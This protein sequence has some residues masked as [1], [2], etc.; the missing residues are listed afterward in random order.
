MRARRRRT[1]LLAA[2]AMLGL[3]ISG[4]G[5]KDADSAKGG[6]GAQSGPANV[7]YVVVQPTSVPLTT[8][9]AARTVAYQSSEVRPQVAGVIQKRLFTEGSIVRKG[10]PLY[11]IDPSLYRAAANEARAN[12]QSARANAEATRIQAERYKPLAAM[13]AV[14]KQDYTNAVAQARQAA[15]SV[16]Q[17][18]ASLQTAQVNLRFTTVPAP[19]TGRIGRSLFTVGALVTTS[20]TDPLATIQQLDPIYV[21]MQQSSS[22]LLALRRSLAAGG[23]AP[24]SATVRLKLED[25]SDYGQ[26]GRVEFSEVVVDQTTGTVTLRA[27][28]PN[29]QGLL[30]PGMFVRA[31]FSQA[32]DTNA[33]LV[34]Q[35]AISR[36]PK[37]NATL[38]LVGPGNKAVQRT[39]TADRAQGASW[40]VTKG[41][42]AGDKV[43]TQGTANLKPNGPIKPVPASSPQRIEPPKQGDAK[44]S[45]QASGK[46]G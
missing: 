9:L 19:I 32:I 46:A 28:F 24:A 42:N 41:L 12:L 7:G 17:T 31:V 10:Q 15:A 1:G 2:V 35:Q 43:I 18:R 27:R 22:D 14:S 6:R 38:Y 29:A 20:Q 33:F 8:E 44:G 11:Q 39:V 4:C 21:D 13:E 37:G 45:G 25:G 5:S 30:L 40:V 3:T 34:P 23:V 16:A 26:T 36:D